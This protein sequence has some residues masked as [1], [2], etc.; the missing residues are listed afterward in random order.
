MYVVVCIS[1]KPATC[2][3]LQFNTRRSCIQYDAIVVYSVYWPRFQCGKQKQAFCCSD[4]VFILAPPHMAGSLLLCGEMEKDVQR[5]ENKPRL[6]NEYSTHSSL[7]L[8][9]D[10][11]WP[12]CKAARIIISTYRTSLSLHPDRRAPG[13]AQLSG[14]SRSYTAAPWEMKS[15]PV[16]SWFWNTNWTQGT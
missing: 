4:A 9:W 8:R 7:T 16:E 3:H 12:V 14:T 15:Q 2:F 6:P 10:Y 13:S 11:P 5:C 1:G